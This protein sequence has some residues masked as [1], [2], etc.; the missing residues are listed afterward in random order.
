MKAKLATMAALA[1][2][3]FNQCKKEPATHLLDEKRAFLE[4][5]RQFVQTAAPA[6]DFVK[7]DWNRAV[8]YKKD[9]AYL[10][11]R[12]PLLGN[13][14]PGQKAVYLSYNNGKFSGNYFELASNTVTTLSLDNVRKCVAPVTGNGQVRDYTV[15]ENGQLLQDVTV[16]AA[17]IMRPPCICMVISICIT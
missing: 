16:T 10:M 17:G 5:A 9:S 3:L 2:L 14:L 8:I 12:V 13:T 7:L 11:V 1:I 4:N 6:A 15:Y